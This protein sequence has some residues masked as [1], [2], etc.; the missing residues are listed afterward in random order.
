MGILNLGR[1]N[2][3]SKSMFEALEEKGIKKSDLLNTANKEIKEARKEDSYKFS[4]D[5][6]ANSKHPKKVCKL[7]GQKGCD[8]K[9]VGFYFHKMC[10]RKIRKD[11]KRMAGD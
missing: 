2:K 9:Y 3:K 11:G 10:I 6:I 5:E 1:A 4:E 8:V 7:C